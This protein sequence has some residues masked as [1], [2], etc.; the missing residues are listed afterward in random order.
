MHSHPHAKNSRLSQIHTVFNFLYVA[1]EA[2]SVGSN[3]SCVSD[4]LPCTVAF[5]VWGGGVS[6]ILVPALSSYDPGSLN[7]CF[8]IQAIRCPCMFVAPAIVNC[9]NYTN[10]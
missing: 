5:K 8:A 9:E 7:P 3:G 2:S 6:K 10:I 4:S 1:E